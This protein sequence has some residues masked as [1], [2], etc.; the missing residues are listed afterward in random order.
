[1]RHQC[2]RCVTIKGAPNSP[3]ALTSNP[4]TICANTSG[5]EFNANTSNTTGAYNLAWTFTPTA[6]T[7]ASGG[8]NTSQLILDWGTSN[9]TV[10]VTAHNACGSG[11]KSL[12][13]NISCRMQGDAAKTV[14]MYPNPASNNVNVEFSTD[15]NETVKLIITDLSGK[16]V[17]QQAFNATVGNNTL[18]A[19]ISHLAKGIY[20]AQLSGSN[21]MSPQKLIVE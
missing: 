12:P 17:M 18:Q 16:V 5:V 1:M 6:A 10:V 19:D 21:L 13:V 8:G 20:M 3:V 15:K 7:Y 2:P 11:A 14:S 4:A 9:G